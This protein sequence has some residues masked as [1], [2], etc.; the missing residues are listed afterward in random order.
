MGAPDTLP[1]SSQTKSSKAKKNSPA[2][3]QPHDGMQTDDDNFWISPLGLQF[4]ANNLYYG[5]TNSDIVQYH[6]GELLG[7]R[8]DTPIP[9]MLLACRE[10]NE[11]ASRFYKPAFTIIP[12]LP[13]TYFDFDRD[14][15][16]LRRN[17]IS[18]PENFYWVHQVLRLLADTDELFRVKNLAVH[19]D[20]QL[21]GYDHVEEIIANYCRH[22]GGL[23]RLTLVM[24]DHEEEILDTSTLHAVDL[25]KVS[26]PFPNAT[27]VPIAADEDHPALNFSHETFS[28]E[29]I[30]GSRSK[31]EDVRDG[32]FPWRVPDVIECKALVSG[33]V[34]GRMK[35]SKVVLRPRDLYE[36][37]L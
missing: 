20:D 14:T 19:F 4:C 17:F 18:P 34:L 8:S 24:L 25:M 11:V 27:M 32:P 35:K 21:G 37:M 7:L 28:R 22:F 30:E 23:E 10:S 31:E 5:S 36:G 9:S 15:L 1:P 2:T 3:P 12:A 6:D 33:D 13:Q 16:Y 29:D 26:V